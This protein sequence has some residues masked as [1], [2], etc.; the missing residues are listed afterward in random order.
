MPTAFIPAA[1]RCGLTGTVWSNT[2]RNTRT[3]G[4]CT[5]ST[6][7]PSIHDPAFC[8]HVEAV[9]ESFGAD[10]CRVCFEM[11]E[12]TAI[13]NP[14]GVSQVIPGVRRGMRFALDEFGSGMSSL[15]S[16]RQ[17]PLDY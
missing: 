5:A 1:E 8:A 9:L 11:S 17:L 14:A 16:L 12:T 2:W 13:A 4:R 3:T 7:R 10:P 15:A 6:C